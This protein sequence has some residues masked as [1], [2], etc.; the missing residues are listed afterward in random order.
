MRK[1]ALVGDLQVRYG[2]SERQACNALRFSRAS[3]RYKSHVKRDSVALSMKIKEIT[4]VYVHYG[5]RRVFVHLRRT[6]WNDN[7]KRVER[8]YRE[9]GLSLARRR[10]RRNKSAQKRQPLQ[11]GLHPNHVWGM[12]FVSDALFDG[13]RLRML[14]VIDLHTR[15]CLGIR[16]GQN[17]KAADVAEE[18]DRIAFLRGTPEIMKTDNGSEFAGKVMDRWAY[19]NGIKMDFSRPGKPTD[20]GT[21][22]SFNGSLRRECLNENWFLSLDDARQKVEEWRRFY[23][24]VRPHSSL[25]WISPS[26]YARKL[27]ALAEDERKNEPDFSS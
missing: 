16:V 24:L 21:V 13:R 22:E 10:P 27:A 2:V 7:H 3:C 18:L 12:D 1:R 20:N 14:T 15:E 19:D 23:N 6:G 26:E 17:L 11:H 4:E 8:L 5:Y 9:Q 25:G